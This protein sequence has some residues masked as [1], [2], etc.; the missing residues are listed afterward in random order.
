MDRHTIRIM[1]GILL[2]IPLLSATCSAISPGPAKQVLILASY[3]PGMKWEDSIDGA[4]KLRLAIS[5]PSAIVNVEYMDTKRIDPNQTR[6]AE[7]KSLYVKKYKNV[8]FDLIIATNTDAFNFLLKNKEDIFPGTPVVFCGVINFNDKMLDG[9]QGFTGVVE[10]YEVLDTISLM[11]QLHPGTRHIA[12]VTDQTTTGKANRKAVEQAI[13]NF[14]QNISFEFLDNLTA[15]E[16][17][18]Q[19]ATLSNESLILLMTFNRDRTGKTL[20]DEDSS[21]LIRGACSIPIYSVYDFYL[22]YGVVGG[23][24]ISGTSQ[25]DQ[26]ADLALRVLR[27]EP[28]DKIPVIKES[29]NLYMFDMFELNRFGVP[30]T[31]L[32][33]DSK[34]INLP[35]SDHACLIGMNLSGLDLSRTNLSRSELQGANLNGANLSEANLEEAWLNQATLIKA[36]LNGANLKGAHLSRSDLSGSDLQNTDLTDADLDEANLTGATLNKTRL[37]KAD[38]TLAKMPGVNLDR[39]ILIGS[40][41]NWAD[42]SGS[43]LY[44]CQFARSDLFGA[45]LSNSDLTGS[46]FT[47]AYL[48]RA[49]LSGAILRDTILENADLTNVNLSGAHFHGTKLDNLNANYADFSGADLTGIVLR[50]MNLQGTVMR[51]TKLRST[52]IEGMI[53][54]HA[55]LSQ[56]DLRDVRINTIYMNNT[57]LSGADLQGAKLTMVVLQDVDLSHA[58]LKGIK[59]DN[60]ALQSLAGSNLDEAKMDAN[61]Q[62]DLKELKA[63]RNA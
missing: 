4:I 34:I 55:D 49:D 31:S 59:Y 27:G 5:M 33:H 22:G 53:F 3:H 58:N 12:I 29:L 28:A 52:S 13:S 56:A 35:F 16:L 1:L 50:S 7:L 20:T 40:R 18:Q 9:K 6:L 17:R 51:R 45:N 23:K 63:S 44:Y 48:P 24:M 39:T 19:I 61:L 37:S 10:A 54:D 8:H 26:A 15:D 60:V 11:L 21:E 42:L 30:L 32:P 47:R 2:L 41:I 46:D 62:K 43:R 25:G 14:K 38:L 36:K 57:N